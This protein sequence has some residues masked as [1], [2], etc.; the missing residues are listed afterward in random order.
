[1]K[2]GTLMDACEPRRGTRAYI[3]NPNTQGVEPID[4]EVYVDPDKM[5]DL[6]QPVVNSEEPE[7]DDPDA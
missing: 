3:F 4:D 5:D 1:M 7:P 2:L 6:L